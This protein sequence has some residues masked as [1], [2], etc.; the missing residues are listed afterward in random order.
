IADGAGNL[1]GNFLDKRGSGTLTLTGTNSYSNRTTIVGG[2][3][4][5]AGAGTIGA[6]NLIVGA[7]TVFDISQ[8]DA[9]ARIIQL[10][11][12]ASG[13]IALGSKTLT[14][15]LSNSFADWAGTITDGGIGGGTGGSVVIAAANGAVRYFGA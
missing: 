7:G 4:A 3:L 12:A 2:T 1:A 14:L 10:G 5:L 13:T 6:G 11:G 9:G 8:T 15:G